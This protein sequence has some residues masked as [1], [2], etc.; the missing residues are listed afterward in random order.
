MT[1]MLRRT[2]SACLCALAVSGCASLWPQTA[3][4]SQGDRIAAGK[5]AKGGN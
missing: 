1:A 3:E 5:K 2:V 4:L